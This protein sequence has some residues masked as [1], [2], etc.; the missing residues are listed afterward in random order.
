MTTIELL[1]LHER[2]TPS[3]RLYLSGKLND[4]TV[5]I[6]LD[7]DAHVPDGATATW[8]MLLRT[9]PAAPQV[10]SDQPTPVPARPQAPPSA[11]AMS[12][13]RFRRKDMSD[14]IPP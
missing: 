5:S 13:D 3:G 7:E 4:A 11:A 14:D 9:K 10:V 2:R 1:I 6:F 8:R 12:N